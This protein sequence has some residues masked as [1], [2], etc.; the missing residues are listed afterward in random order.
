MLTARADSILVY[1]ERQ[2]DIPWSTRGESA[3][4]S[5]RVKRAN[6]G[7]KLVRFALRVYSFLWYSLMTLPASE[8]RQ[9]VES[10]RF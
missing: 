8:G 4:Q 7:F 10:T 5:L 1:D 9:P 3:G 6:G 2:F